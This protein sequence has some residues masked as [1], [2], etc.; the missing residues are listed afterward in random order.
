MDDACLNT[1]KELWREGDFYSDSIHVTE[2]G[3]I[4]INH[5]GHVIVAPLKSWYDAGNLFL[6]VNPKLKRWK[7]RLA[8]WL[9][10]EDKDGRYSRLLN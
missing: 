6:C 7:W 8:M 2:H 10:K 4:G 5:G 1:D 9:L 3:G